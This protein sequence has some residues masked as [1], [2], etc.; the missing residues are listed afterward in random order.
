MADTYTFANVRRL[1][2]AIA[3]HLKETGEAAHGVV[4][5]YDTR[6]LSEDFAAA[7]AGTLAQ[8]GVRS[9]LAVAAV[10]TPTWPTRSSITT[11]RP[12]SRSRPATTRRRTTGSSSRGR[13]VG[14][15]C[16]R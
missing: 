5:G 7:A 4:V 13:R 1:T 16:P 15:R 8:A 6:F 9:R 14:P 11:R 10:P 3:D 12:G 2:R